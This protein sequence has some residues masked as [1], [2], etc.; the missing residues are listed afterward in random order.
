MAKWLC[1]NQ[2]MEQ[3]GLRRWPSPFD[4]IFSAPEMVKHC[5]NESTSFNSFL[6]Q[7]K[8]I[9]APC[10]KARFLSSSRL[11]IFHHFSFH[12]KGHP[13]SAPNCAGWPWDLLRDAASWG[14]FQ[15]PQSNAG[16]GLW[17]LRIQREI[18]SSPHGVQEIDADKVQCALS[19]LQ[20]GRKSSAEGCCTSGTLSGT[21]FAMCLELSTFGSQSSHKNRGPS[22][23]SLDRESTL[24]QK[25]SESAAV[26]VWTFCSRDARWMALQRWARHEDTKWNCIDWSRLS[27]VS[28][29]NWTFDE[30][31]YT[32]LPFLDNLAFNSLLPH[33]CQNEGI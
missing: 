25:E 9:P 10:N 26:G 21:Q 19:A 7:T 12:L 3:W 11:T 33:L 22:L 30:V 6:D 4:W 24:K 8:Y 1:N 28:F 23:A 5:L 2:A 16:E 13:S 20:L 29:S 18:T 14:D 31:Q 27:L 17:F 15:S 32:W